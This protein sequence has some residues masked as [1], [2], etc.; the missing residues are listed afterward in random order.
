MKWIAWIFTVLSGL[1]SV[2]A[3][4]RVL[5]VIAGGHGAGAPADWLAILCCAFLL[6]LAAWSRLFLDG[7]EARAGVDEGAVAATVKTG[8]SGH[9]MT[10]LYSAMI[11][12]A[13]G[14]VLSSAGGVTG[15]PVHWFVFCLK[16]PWAIPLVFVVI[17]F[18]CSNLIKMERYGKAMGRAAKSW[19]IHVQ[20][21]FWAVSGLGVVCTWCVFVYMGSCTDAAYIGHQG[22]RGFCRSTWW[23][24]LAFDV[25]P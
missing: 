4:P 13:V 7:L 15:F 16:C 3:L 8:V 1:V 9:H 21:A 11:V 10:L 2:V 19:V 20:P 14:A 22:L 17:P 5:S 6:V 24:F 23:W 18:I 25:T 12:S